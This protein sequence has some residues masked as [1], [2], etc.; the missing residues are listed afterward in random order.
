MA[1]SFAAEHSAVP[2]S[3][4]IVQLGGSDNHL[5]LLKE[6]HKMRDERVTNLQCNDVFTVS[7]YDLSC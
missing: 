4:H 5:L 7:L 6:A 1:D 2:H 3:P